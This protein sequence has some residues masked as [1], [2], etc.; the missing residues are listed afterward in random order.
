MLNDR[1]CLPGH[2]DGGSMLKPYMVHASVLYSIFKHIKI[3]VST[4]K[5]KLCNPTDLNTKERG[6]MV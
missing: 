2:T 4:F 5:R 6:G 1:A 3:I